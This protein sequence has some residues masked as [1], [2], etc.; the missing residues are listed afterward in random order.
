MAWG[1]VMRRDMYPGWDIVM[2]RNADMVRAM[3][4]RRAITMVM[5]KDTGMEISM[6]VNT[7]ANTAANNMGA[8]INGT[9]V[10]F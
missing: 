5:S 8:I 2:A 7:A 6:A 9:V 10:D 4:T 1:T 3:V